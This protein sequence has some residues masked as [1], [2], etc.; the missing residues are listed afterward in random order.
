MSREDVCGFQ[1]VGSVML[2]GKPSSQHMR[3]AHPGR[4]VLRHA[5]VE[6]ARAEAPQRQPSTF[7]E[8]MAALRNPAVSLGD[9]DLCQRCLY[10]ESPYLHSL[11]SPCPK[12]ATASAEAPQG[13]T[14]N[15]V[16]GECALREAGL[17][18]SP[19]GARCR[20]YDEKAAQPETGNEARVPDLM[21]ISDANGR[22]LNC[23]SVLGEGRSC[24]MCFAYAAGRAAE[25]E[26][27]RQILSQHCD[28]DDH[29]ER[30]IKCSA[31]RTR[32]DIAARRGSGT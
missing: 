30:Q 27:L 7:A 2:C 15:C 26:A 29:P 1:Y 6:P 11:G 4:E 24:K 14:C 12:S 32:S 25:N 23:P 10:V 20:E 21:M 8:V 22:C 13:E 28:C 5:F 9:L 16:P 19:G 31:C 17:V 18:W 3:G